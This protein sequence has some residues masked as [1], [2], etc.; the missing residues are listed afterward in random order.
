MGGF[1]DR[2]DHHRSEVFDV[3]QFLKKLQGQF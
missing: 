2:V 1:G 3:G